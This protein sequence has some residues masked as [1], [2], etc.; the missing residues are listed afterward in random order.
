MKKIEQYFMSL[1]IKQDK[2]TGG[3]EN[4]NEKKPVC[5]H[6]HTDEIVPCVYGL[7][8]V[9]YDKKSGRMDLHT[10]WGACAENEL[11]AVKSSRTGQK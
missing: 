9:E 3:M 11:L 5:P 7:L 6:G 4:K 2:K 8:T 1:I 10:G